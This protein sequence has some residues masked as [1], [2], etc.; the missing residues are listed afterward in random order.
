MCCPLRLCSACVV[1]AIFA[2]G[3]DD[4]DIFRRA[5]RRAVVQGDGDLLVA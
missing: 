4:D 1:V 2:G 5:V 3:A